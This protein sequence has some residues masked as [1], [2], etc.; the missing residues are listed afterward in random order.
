[1]SDT[2]DDLAAALG[3][4]LAA[5]ARTGRRPDAAEL[6]TCRHLGGAAAAEGV[7]VRDLVMTA[8][9]VAEHAAADPVPGA[10]T[11]GQARAAG[12]A[13]VT[14]LRDVTSALLDGHDSAQRQAALVDA[15]MR[16]QFI[17]DLLH[18]R[19]DAGRL[20]EQAERFGLLLAGR[21]VVAVARAD[22]PFTNEVVVRVDAGLTGRFGQHNVLVAVRDGLLVCV[23]PSTLRGGPGEFAHHLLTV[24][25]RPSGWQIGVGRPQ[26]GP[27]GVMRSFE[28]ARNALHLAARLGFTTPVLHAADLLVFPVLLRDRAAIVDLVQSVLGPLRDARGGV[29]P[30]LDTLTAFFDHHGNITA[31]ARVLHLT[32]RAVTYRL[33]RITALTGYAPTEPMQRFTLEA[34]VLG[35]RLLQWP[36]VELD[37]HD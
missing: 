24:L 23:L 26:S 10:V 22:A 5:T 8:L 6:S 7:G 21:H 2:T 13:L 25:G 29:Q 11:A 14:A 19:H 33:D 9:H 30:M 35:A 18:G 37:E 36:A 17:D 4:I 28:E 27:A 3:D 20:A 15:R 16:Q 32:S 31:A 1:M 34:A 12:R